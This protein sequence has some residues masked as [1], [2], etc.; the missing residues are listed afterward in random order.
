MT[1]V[2]A[3]RTFDGVPASFVRLAPGGVVIADVH[4]NEMLA[5]RGQWLSLPHWRPAAPPPPLYLAAQPSPGR[6]A[7]LFALLVA[8]EG[9]GFVRSLFFN[10]WKQARR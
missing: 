6:L 2:F 4:G 3:T 5:S 1:D 9:I 7:V 8:C 10:A